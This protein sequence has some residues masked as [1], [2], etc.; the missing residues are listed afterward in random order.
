MKTPTQRF[1]KRRRRGTPNISLSRI[2]ADVMAVGGIA[3]LLTNE[4]WKY[5]D[6]DDTLFRLITLDTGSLSPGDAL[7]K[8]GFV[9]KGSD[10]LSRRCRPMAR[11][12]K[13]KMKFGKLSP[14]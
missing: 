11:S 8:E 12:S 14:G 3:A 10:K 5:G 2:A 9:C 4:V 13:P 6:D 7:Q 1:R